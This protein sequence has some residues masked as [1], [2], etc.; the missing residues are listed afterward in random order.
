MLG[1]LLGEHPSDAGL[2]WAVGT[3]SDRE[4]PAAWDWLL[5]R[6]NEQRDTLVGAVPAG[7][8]L[9][10][11]ASLRPTARDVAPDLWRYRSMVADV[12]HVAAG[13][14]VADERA[15]EEPEAG[16]GVAGADRPAIERTDLLAVVGVEPSPS[17]RP[18]LAR[19]VTELQAGR[20]EEAYDLAV[21]AIDLAA[22]DDDRSLAGG[23]LALVLEG[24]GDPRPPPATPP[25]PST[26][27]DRSAVLSPPAC[28]ASWPGP[29]T[30][31][32]GWAQRCAWST[33]AA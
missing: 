19:V 33:S 14:V 7:L 27:S 29:V 10:L 20:G 28:S 5:R 32:S 17:L 23:W 26:L 25:P 4:W 1:W 15:G 9:V 16:A 6:L 2:V 24:K 30:T 11:P 21:R 18:T 3:G 31:A 8:V 22:T 13:H 12:D